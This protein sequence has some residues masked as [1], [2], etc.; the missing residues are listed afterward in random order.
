MQE[1]RLQN[2]LTMLCRA[3]RAGCIFQVPA[4]FGSGFLH[5]AMR[6]T[7]CQLVVALRG[8]STQRP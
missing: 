7:H 2:V 3:Q 8:W 4:V 5:G 1:R 6:V